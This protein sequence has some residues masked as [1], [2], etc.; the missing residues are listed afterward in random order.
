MTIAGWKCATIRDSC[1]LY[2][3][4]S[5]ATSDKDAAFGRSSQNLPR[6][7]TDLYCQGHRTGAPY[8]DTL[9]TIEK[10]KG[11]RKRMTASAHAAIDFQHTSRPVDLAILGQPRMTAQRLYA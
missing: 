8:I 2:L 5:I 7:R 10:G 6:N 11:T 3:D 4:R 1:V 9:A